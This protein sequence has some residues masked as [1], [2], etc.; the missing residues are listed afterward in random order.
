VITG[1]VGSTPVTVTVAVQ[2]AWPAAFSAVIVT[3]TLPAPTRLP[4][5]GDW[6][7]C[8][9][10]PVATTSATRF[11][12]AATQAPFAEIVLSVAQVVI[13]GA[14]G[15][16]T[17]TVNWQSAPAVLVHV[18]IVMPT[19]KLEPDAGVQVTVPQSPLVV[20]AE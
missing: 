19:L 11:G 7:T 2:V 9:E 20:G 5:A 4:A 3:V 6:E 15:G 13:A 16:R 17:L 18:T 8:V 12:M 14:L 1:A 10:Q